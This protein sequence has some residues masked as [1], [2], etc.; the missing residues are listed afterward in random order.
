MSALIK[1]KILV[2]GGTGYIG[3]HTIVELQQSGYEVI[4]VDNLSKSNIKI[5]DQVKAITGIAPEFEKLDL[6]DKA[7]VFN[8]IHAQP[9][10]EGIISLCSFQI[11]RRV[12]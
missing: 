1:G 4:I 2:T 8:F 9:S 6:R 11:G 10:L 3:A 5:I 12:G 7:G